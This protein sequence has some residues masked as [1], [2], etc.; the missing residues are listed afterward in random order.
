ME[1][2]KIYNEDC[3]DFMKRIPNNFFDLIVTDPPYGLKQ[4][5]EQN[6][7]AGYKGKN[8][9]GTRKYYGESNWDMKIPSK[10]YFDEMFR[11]SKNQVIFGGNYMTDH[12]PPSSCWVV[13]DKVTGKN[14]FADCE[15][16][17]TS[18]NKAVRKFKFMWKGMFQE[19]MNWKEKRFHPTQKPVALGRWI[20]EK[21]GNKGDLIFD[22][23]AGCGSFL[24]A[25]KQLGFEFVG[26]EINNAYVKIAKQRL[27]QNILSVNEVK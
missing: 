2:N 3:L 15:L 19:Q 26:C 4:D 25:C 14:D 13:W 9:Y 27:C 17:W 1:K 8:Q 10:D 16:A 7:R 23:F 11:T 22:P 21:F 12:L 6:R 24:V 18:F 5:K 20:L